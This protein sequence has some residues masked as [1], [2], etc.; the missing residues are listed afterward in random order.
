MTIVA[1]LAM[2]SLQLLLWILFAIALQLGTFIGI[3]FWRHWRDFMA[4]KTE[5]VATGLPAWS[6]PPKRQAPA[7]PTAW[8]GFRPF[9]VT[10]KVI[11][12]QAKS[13]QSFYLESEDGQPLPS[14]QPGQFLTFSLDIPTATGEL[15][16]IIRCYSLSDAPHPDYYRISIKRVPA[17]PGSQFPPGRSSNHLHDHIEVG[18]LLQARAP[19]G[20]FHLDRGDA[21]VVLVAGGIGITPLLSMLNWS[22]AEQPGREIW[23][24]YGVRNSRELI[25]KAHLETLAAAHPNFHLRICFSD[26]LPE[27]QVNRDYQHQGRV[28]VAL[29]RLE[30]GLKPYHFYVCGPDASDG[31]ADSGPGGLGRAGGAHSLRG[32]WP[33]LD[34][35]PGPGLPVSAGRRGSG[36]RKRHQGELCQIRPASR[37]AG[38][39]GQP[40]R[41][42][43]SSWYFN[44]FR[45][46]SGRLRELPDPDRIRRGV[47]PSG[48]RF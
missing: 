31:D 48:S 37:L 24:F 35:A 16:P 40:A 28:G 2:T 20:H 29:F 15:E 25:M 38:R 13:I 19:A 30:L 45:L 22:L 1:K 34:Q 7:G 5:L 36:D 6:E 47:L 18:D 41:I 17:P 21:P 26:P 4:L 39:H 44:Q 43:R 11:E 14:F 9:R 42:C 46:P 33:G 10:R 12:D 32:L 8:V 27:D 23:L 3:A